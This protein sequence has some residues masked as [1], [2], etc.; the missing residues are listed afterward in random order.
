MT[1]SHGASLA[2][3]R[4]KKGG[5]YIKWDQW[6]Q[7]LLA[8]HK[9]AGKLCD[10]HRFQR[11]VAVISQQRPALAAARIA[12]PGPITRAPSQPSAIIA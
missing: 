4:S 1:R 6:G 12:A 8:G 10:L 11:L 7:R 2:A 5:R 9:G 3:R